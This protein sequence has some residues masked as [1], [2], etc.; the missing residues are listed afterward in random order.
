MAKKK[1]TKKVEL[2]EVSRVEINGYI[3][4]RPGSP[5]V[6]DVYGGEL[7][8]V[9]VHIEHAAH[10]AGVLHAKGGER[11]VLLHRDGMPVREQLNEQIRRGAFLRSDIAA[12][13]YCGI[14]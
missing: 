9:E 3:P 8:L 14:Q 13:L 12:Q 7:P 4:H 1:E 5:A 2:K 10:L 11:V 6:H